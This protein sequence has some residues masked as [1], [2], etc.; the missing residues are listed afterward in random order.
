MLLELCYLRKQKELSKEM[1]SQSYGNTGGRGMK[2]T[3]RESP[4]SGCRD[5]PV[6]KNAGCSGRVPFPFPT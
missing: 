6:A 1:E 5:G 2:E 3:G 4:E